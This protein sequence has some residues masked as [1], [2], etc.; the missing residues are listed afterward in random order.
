M[1]NEL[2]NKGTLNH[3]SEDLSA[4]N[5]RSSEKY[6]TFQEVENSL[7][8]RLKR[9]IMNGGYSWDT[10][11]NGN[12]FYEPTRNVEKTPVVNEPVQKTIA[13][14]THEEVLEILNKEND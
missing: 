5:P 11:Y 4:F 9:Y 7:N 3:I 12:I 6:V 2:K 10:R 1:S 8:D 13:D 14:R